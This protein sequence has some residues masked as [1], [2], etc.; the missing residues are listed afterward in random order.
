MSIAPELLRTFALRAADAGLIE[1]FNAEDLDA[2]ATRLDSVERAAGEAIRERSDHSVWLLLSG[3]ITAA[4]VPAAGE[5][6]D[7][8]TLAPGTMVGDLA[9]L[10]DLPEPIALVAKTPCHLARLDRAAFW[11]WTESGEPAAAHFHHLLARLLTRRLRFANA[12]FATLAID[13]DPDRRSL[14]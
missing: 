3:E 9:L 12:R 4:Y 13:E 8:G 1:T 6:V 10:L 14:Y 2:L 11:R 7:L 5:E